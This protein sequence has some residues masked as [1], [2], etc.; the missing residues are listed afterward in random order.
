MNDYTGIGVRI[1]GFIE[2]SETVAKR[3]V[4]YGKEHA[5]CYYL[6]GR[7]RFSH[8]AVRYRMTST[9]RLYYCGAHGLRFA[10]DYL[11]AMQSLEPD[12][13][14]EAL[15][16]LEVKLTELLTPKAI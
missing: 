1:T 15:G 8:F 11:T 6:E 16:D 4:T 7:Y 5:H 3:L 13:I 12:G 2:I 9:N 10:R 14:D